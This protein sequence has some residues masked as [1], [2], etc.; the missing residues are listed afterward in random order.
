M[1]F[2]DAN[3]SQMLNRHAILMYFE[4]VSGL[5]VNLGKSELLLV[6]AIEDLDE[7]AGY[8]VAK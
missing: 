2:C 4:V 7:L 1:V 6:G 5:K 3:R 8:F